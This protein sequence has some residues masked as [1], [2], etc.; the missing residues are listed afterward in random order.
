[1]AHSSLAP[2]HWMSAP[3]RRQCLR[4]GQL[5]R[6]LSRR[7]L[8]ARG[9]GRRLRTG[10]GGVPDLRQ[11]ERV[12]G[13]SLRS[14]TSKLRCGELSQWMLRGNGLSSGNERRAVRYWRRHL[15]NLHGDRCLHGWELP[16]TTDLRCFD[17]SVRLLQ[18]DDLSDGRCRLRMRRKRHRL[19]DVPSNTDLHWRHVQRVWVPTRRDGTGEWQLYVR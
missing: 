4:R 14:V 6:V 2:R 15:Y 19:R 12:R 10:R 13:A 3:R 5:H 8:R 7:H 1:M 16:G 18:R 9:F 11:R 17:V